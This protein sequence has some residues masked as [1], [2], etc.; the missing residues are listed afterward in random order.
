[1]AGHGHRPMDPAFIKLNEM[2]INRYKY[3]RW[4]PKTARQSIMFILVVPGILGFTAYQT[5]GLW[6]F[7]AKRKGDSLLER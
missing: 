4:T 2:Q 6:D 1:M 5:D 3:F 7:R